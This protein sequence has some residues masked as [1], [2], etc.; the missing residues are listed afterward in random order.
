MQH[1]SI[2]Y[3][4]CDRFYNFDTANCDIKFVSVLSLYNTARLQLIVSDSINDY[5]SYGSHVSVQGILEDN[6][7]YKTLFTIFSIFIVACAVDVYLSQPFETISA[8]VLVHCT[9]ETE[10]ILLSAC[11]WEDL[12]LGFLGGV[13]SLKLFTYIYSVS[14]N[15]SAHILFNLYSDQLV[16]F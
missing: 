6:F 2:Y 13:L 7:Q 1:V 3:R 11:N 4:S 5:R 12:Q 8:E 14:W 9:A 15:S 10:K 16:R